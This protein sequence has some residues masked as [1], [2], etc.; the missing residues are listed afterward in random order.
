LSEQLL[1]LGPVAR[2][3]E[4]GLIA[5]HRGAAGYHISRILSLVERVGA[6]R[7]VEA[8]RHDVFDSPAAFAREIDRGRIPE[9]TVG[10]RLCGPGRH[11]G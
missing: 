3:F 6:P 1:R 10:G 9:C 4:D 5:E 11:V 8:L 2:E 7:V